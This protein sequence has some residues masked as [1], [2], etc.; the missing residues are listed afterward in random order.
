MLF[1]IILPPALTNRWNMI[2]WC[3]EITKI[4]Y[5]FW[6]GLI[7]W[8]LY[9]IFPAT[10]GSFNFV[11]LCNITACIGLARWSAQTTRLSVSATTAT[12]NTVWALKLVLVGNSASIQPPT[13]LTSALTIK[14]RHEI[15]TIT[16][17]DVYH[18]CVP[19]VIK[20]TIYTL[21]IS[22][23]NKFGHQQVYDDMKAKDHV[24]SEQGSTYHGSLTDLSDRG[25]VAVLEFTASSVA[26]LEREQKCKVGIRRYGK[27]DNQV[28]FR[29]VYAGFTWLS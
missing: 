10:H 3:W 16:L 20:L 4:T 8:E 15:P 12:R 7:M 21:Y 11:F 13:L 28:T 29:Y 25:R 24:L 1:Q 27:K 5:I 19:Y 9:R 17:V 18:A 14:R 22:R 23:N 26:V 2:P 6:G